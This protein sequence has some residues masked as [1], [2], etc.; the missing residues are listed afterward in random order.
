MQA[1]KGKITVYQNQQMDFNAK[2]QAA[3]EW[4]IDSL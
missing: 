4:A 2:T 3:K 1:G